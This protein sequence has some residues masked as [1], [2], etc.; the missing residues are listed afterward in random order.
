ME[1]PATEARRHQYELV[2]TMLLTVGT[3]LAGFALFLTTLETPDERVFRW[4]RRLSTSSSIS[5]FIA[6]VLSVVSAYYIGREDEPNAEIS[7]ICLITAIVLDS[8]GFGLLF[9]GTILYS[10]PKQKKLLNRNN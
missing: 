3:F 10:Y 1:H 9:I 7:R 4:A 8:F 6:M 5:F 2:S